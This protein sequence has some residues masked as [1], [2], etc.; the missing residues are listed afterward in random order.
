MKTRLYTLITLFTFSLTSLAQVPTAAIVSVYT[1]GVKISPDMAESLMRIEVTKTGKF[2]VLDKL[3]MLEVLNE[4]QVD[5]SNCFGKKCLTSVGSQAGVDKMITGAIENLGK[6]I[7]ITVK[8]LDVKTGN[9]DK[10]AIEEFINLDTEVQTMM[11]ITTNKA[12]GI[13]NDPELLNNFVYFNQ[14]PEAP[15]TYIKNNGPRMGMSYVGGDMGQVLQNPASMGGFDATPI[16]TQIGYQFEGSYL[17]AGNFQALI[18]GLV[19]LTG[20]EQNMF[21]PSIAILNGFR[22]SKNGWEI[23]FGPTFRLTRIADGYYENNDISNDNWRID[24]DW[25]VPANL[26]TL[27]PWGGYLDNPNDSYS[28]MD[29]RGDIKLQAG[30][31]WA[32]G[33]T[34]HSGYLNIPV[35]AFLSYNKNG[36]YLGLSMGF[37]IT[38][39]D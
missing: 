37:N 29:S 30:W 19:F 3:D 1:Q 23:G 26:D 31:V 21:N 6:K 7:V 38:K 18:E 20:V 25:R 10:I 27:S 5:V 12:L 8:L 36:Y 4:N 15:V 24:S 35:N 14:P 22:S 11:Q 13:E 17:S 9:Y 2:N 16:M 33:K 28:R 39:K 32:L 34:F